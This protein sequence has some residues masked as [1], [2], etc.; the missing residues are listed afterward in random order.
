M[1]GK[2]KLLDPTVDLDL[3]N[4]CIAAHIERFLKEHNGLKQFRLNNDILKQEL[5]REQKA[6]DKIEK[7][8]VE[9]KNK[10]SM[11]TFSALKKSRF[12][13]ELDAIEFPKQHR[14]YLQK[15]SE[16]EADRIRLENRIVQLKDGYEDADVYTLYDDIAQEVEDYLKSRSQYYIQDIILGNDT[17]LNDA[18][19]PVEY[20]T[21]ALTE[22]MKMVAFFK[23]RLRYTLEHYMLEKLPV[24]DKDKK[25]WL[26]LLD[27]LIY[28]VNSPNGV[29]I[30]GS[31]GY[32]IYQE[33]AV[34]IET[35]YKKEN[36]VKSKLLRLFNFFIMDVPNIDTLELLEEGMHDILSCDL[37]HQINGA[38]KTYFKLNLA[39]IESR[40][41][42]IWDT[43]YSAVNQIDIFK[44][45]ENDP[46][47]RVIRLNTS[48]TQDDKRI[49]RLE[50]EKR[51]MDSEAIILSECLETGYSLKVLALYQQKQLNKIR[52]LLQ[53]RHDRLKSASE[54]MQH[55]LAF[56][57]DYGTSYKKSDDL[58]WVVHGVTMRYKLTD[59]MERVCDELEA[60]QSKQRALEPMK[61]K[62]ETFVS[63]IN[64]KVDERKQYY[65]GHMDSMSHNLR[66]R[67][68][69][70]RQ[71]RER[72]QNKDR[73]MLDKLK[74]QIA[75]VLSQYQKKEGVGCV[76]RYYYGKK[77]LAHAKDL[78]RVVQECH[79]YMAACD[80]L[81]HYF[82]QVKELH[83]Y[84]KLRDHSFAS[85]LLMM[86][87]SNEGVFNKDAYASDEASHQVTLQVG[88]ES[89]NRV[90]Q[91]LRLATTRHH[92][93]FQ[94]PA[95]AIRIATAAQAVKVAETLRNYFS[96]SESSHYLSNTVL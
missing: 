75:L 91:G 95:N 69:Q 13:P 25:S 73:E 8:Q 1:S 84:V 74:R 2:K 80:I 6:L 19:G 27:E 48:F 60:V 18:F 92:L 32:S 55:M 79:S 52:E 3:V 78:N 40:F 42:I 21:L 54:K 9:F 49:L 62:W 85:R 31:E 72:L 45:I 37:S 59:L 16:Y 51:F 82:Y 22:R 10:P 38:A 24:R 26:S 7:L 34:A 94:H 96:E 50:I 33:L 4:Q 89:D 46:D 11:I 23:A 64:Q 65:F 47:C 70:Y 29:I 87:F 71:R 93:F 5:V 41:N 17:F 56:W 58:A 35:L 81:Q 39:W 57:C 68:Q 67:E 43:S 83:G 28:F 36:K 44:K 15:C 88:E 53:N 14:D 86:L 61:I 90:V 20:I 30:P 77:G 76:E 63:D 66:C 12:F